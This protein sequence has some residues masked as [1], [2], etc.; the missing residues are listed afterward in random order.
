MLFILYLVYVNKKI[1]KN[2]YFDRKENVSIFIL[3]FRLFFFVSLLFFFFL[4]SE[5]SFMLDFILEFIRR[6]FLIDRYVV[7][8]RALRDVVYIIV[9]SVDISFNS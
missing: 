6:C 4:Y 2:I 7:Y 9:V 8:F 5:F 3:E 1:I